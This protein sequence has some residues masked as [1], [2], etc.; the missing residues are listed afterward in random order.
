MDTQEKIRVRGEG[1]KLK[2]LES[3]YT[4]VDRHRLEIR[5]EEVEQVGGGEKWGGGKWVDLG[6]FAW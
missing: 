2:G 5:V 3:A 4:E 1:G 6:T